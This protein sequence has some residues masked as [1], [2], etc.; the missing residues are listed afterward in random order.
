[1]ISSRENSNFTNDERTYP[2]T[3]SPI[4]HGSSVIP[5]TGSPAGDTFI[6]GV[7]ITMLLCFFLLLR[8]TASP[9]WNPTVSSE[10]FFFVLKKKHVW[11]ITHW[12][13]T[14]MIMTTHQSTGGSKESSIYIILLRSLVLPIHLGP[15][16][17]NTYL[18]ATFLITLQW[19]D[20]SCSLFPNDV[21]I[22]CCPSWW[23]ACSPTLLLNSQEQCVFFSTETKTSWK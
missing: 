10:F 7:S 12:I 20:C 18:F 16:E 9:F 11:N 1:M 23:A 17:H 15:F 4:F 8:S 6:S 13:P 2:S 5:P 3:S 21:F 22:Y 19:G 14:D